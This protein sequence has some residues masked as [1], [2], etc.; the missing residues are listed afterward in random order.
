MPSF[1]LL[2]E[3]PHFNSASERRAHLPEPAGI[4]GLGT[5]RPGSECHRAQALVP[6]EGPRA[7]AEGLWSKGPGRFS[8][9][10]LPSLGQPELTNFLRSRGGWPH[11]DAGL[12]KLVLPPERRRAG[13]KEGWPGVGAL[14]S[15]Q[16][17]PGP[18]SPGEGK[19]SLIFLFCF[20]LAAASL[21]TRCLAATAVLW[22]LRTPGRNRRGQGQRKQSTAVARALTSWGGGVAFTSRACGGPGRGVLQ[23]QWSVLTSWLCPSPAL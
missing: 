14:L 11:P 4:W 13:A 16:S 8:Q 5:E 19:R 2:S 3:W 6:L 17:H 18:L 10:R 9:G 20:P 7:N 23:P 15:S 22:F 1:G 21:L 12:G